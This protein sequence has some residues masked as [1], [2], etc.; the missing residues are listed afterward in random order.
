MSLVSRKIVFTVTNDLSY[1]QRMQRICTTLSGQGANVLLVGRTTSS[2]QVLPAF[3]FKT[4]RLNCLFQ[5]GKLFYLEYN[6][7]LFLLLLTLRCDAICA[8]D[9]DT[10]LPATLV[11]RLLGKK[12]GYDAHEFFT[13]VPEVVGRKKVQAVWHAVAKFCIPKTDFRYTV[14]P[15]LAVKLEEVYGA[16]FQVVRNMPFLQPV[17]PPV[18]SL[19]GI[20][21]PDQ[22][23]L[24][25]GALNVGRGLEA[26]IK[27][28]RHLSM[29]VVL[30]GE[31]DLSQEL[32]ALTKRENLQDRV[33]FL[34]FVAPAVLKG[35][36]QKAFIGYNLLENL[37]QS[38]YYSLANKFFDYTM[39]GV[40]CLNSAFPE[41]VALQDQYNL[42]VSCNLNEK[43]IIETVNGLVKNQEHYNL[44]CQ[45]CIKA[46]EEL[47]W[48]NEART[49]A[50]I[51][52]REVQ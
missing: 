34:G 15:K 31:G 45:N 2:S 51:Y 52:E 47:N 27:A 9:L 26:L 8:I 12:L 1:D 36:T 3:S 42:S 41:Y 21:L 50:S 33:V 44:L 16:P 46:R 30:A 11:A 28:S 7:R 13:E 32:R 5:K 18:A 37:G 6:L 35:L 4:K 39:A 23:V 25:Q 24:Y 14:G 40:P 10:L 22:F 29:P 19:S 17:D 48:E 38:Y 49:L 20:S 43:D